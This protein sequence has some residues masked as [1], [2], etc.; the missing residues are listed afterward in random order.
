MDLE[1]S[2]LLWV[3]VTAECPQESDEL[4]EKVTTA[5]GAVIDFCDGIIGLEYSLE[6]IS[7]CGANVDRYLAALDSSLRFL[8]G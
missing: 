1:E 7:D 8:G 3:P 5:N 2:M 4:I 6:I